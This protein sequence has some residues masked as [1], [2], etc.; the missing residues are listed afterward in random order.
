MSAD[1]F[2]HHVEDSINYYSCGRDSSAVNDHSIYTD[3]AKPS[4]T[5]FSATCESV[6]FSGQNTTIDARIRECSYLYV[7]TY[8]EGRKGPS[9]HIQSVPHQRHTEDCHETSTIT[10]TFKHSEHSY[11]DV[12]SSHFST[13]HG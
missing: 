9:H 11:T 8:E 12:N 3:Q 4:D 5:S 13:A 6:S 7:G 2:H 10:D 1:S